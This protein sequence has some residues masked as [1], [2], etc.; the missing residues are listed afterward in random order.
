MYYNSLSLKKTKS[1][2]GLKVAM[3]DDHVLLLNGLANVIDSFNGYKVVIKATNGLEFIEALKNSP[4][5][6]V[7]ILDVNMPLMDGHETALWLINNHPEIPIIILTMFDSELMLMRMM[8]LGVQA[9]LKKDVHPSELNYALDAVFTEGYY[10]PQSVSGKMAALF[11][12]SRDKHSK[13][14]APFSANE[15]TFLKLVGTELTYKEIADEMCVSERTIENYRTSLCDK[16]SLKNRTDLAVFAM[17]NG[18]I[19]F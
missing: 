8:Q 19:N 4:L 2:S 13:D 15:I 11:Q 7:I 6:D 1:T 16:L 14:A 12:K 10:Y 3:V 5:P 18:I 17:R 9:F